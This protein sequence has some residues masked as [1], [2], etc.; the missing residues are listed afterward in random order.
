MLPT[1]QGVIFN[2]T[3]REF[4]F[5]SAPVAPRCGFLAPAAGCSLLRF[6][7]CDDS[8]CPLSKLALT[9][10]VTIDGS[11]PRAD[12]VRRLI[13]HRAVGRL[14]DQ[15]RGAAGRNIFV[16]HTVEC[17]R[18]SRFHVYFQTVTDRYWAVTA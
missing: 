17:D 4:T 3:D 13:A 16:T 6:P 10:T 1:E 7:R 2:S 9:P 18:R 8:L 5:E 11:T 12:S 15:L 14:S